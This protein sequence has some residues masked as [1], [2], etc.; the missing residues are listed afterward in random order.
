MSA[1]D[2]GNNLAAYDCRHA[3]TGGRGR[4][5]PGGPETTII[6]GFRGIIAAGILIAAI[7]PRPEY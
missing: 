1:C 4:N 7:R 6:P 2:V 3:A 5:D